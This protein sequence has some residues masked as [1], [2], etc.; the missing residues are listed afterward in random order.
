MRAPDQVLTAPASVPSGSL[1]QEG[2]W[3]STSLPEHVALGK[4]THGVSMLAWAHNEEIL[5][6]S[7]LERAVALLDRVAIDWEIVLVDDGSTDR[8]NE[9]A[10]TFAAREPRV[11]LIR[12]QHNL[13]VGMACR[14]AIAQASKEFLFWQTV[15]WSYDI[16]KL[17]VFLELL[18]HFDAVQGIRPVPIRLMSYIPVL[19]SIYR[20]RRRSD[21]FYKAIISLGNY[22]VLTILFGVRFH[23]FQNVTFYRT[24][25]VQALPLVARTSFINPELLLRSYYQG[26]R[27]IEVP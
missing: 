25:V 19:R 15:D 20:V 24:R 27:F 17:R 11:R 13:N 16:G 3:P 22:Y 9:I 8:T 1:P 4:F 21:S 10:T 12:H 18:M 26:A 14:T 6:E 2:G 7:F 5:I 23:D